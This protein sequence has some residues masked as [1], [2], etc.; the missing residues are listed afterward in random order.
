MLINDILDSCPEKDQL[1]II[2]FKGDT[3]EFVSYIEFEAKNELTYI[4]KFD[5]SFTDNV[6]NINC[7][8]GGILNKS[9]KT[10]RSFMHAIE[11]FYKEFDIGI[12][13]NK[14]VSYNVKEL[15]VDVLFLKP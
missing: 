12:K 8:I 6:L 5:V 10:F 4:C 13:V 2:Y 3:S 11:N 14:K 9:R 1:K 7:E 15:L